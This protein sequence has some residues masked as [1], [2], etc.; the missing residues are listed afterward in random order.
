MET[1][2]HVRQAMK[3]YKR[4]EADKS[5]GVNNPDLHQNRATIHE[6]QEDYA[7]ALEGYMLASLLDPA[8][9]TPKAATEQLKAR[10][11]AICDLIA[12]N[13]R[14]K[15]KKIAGFVKQLKESK[16]KGTHVCVK[17]CEDG[18]IQFGKAMQIAVVSIF[19]GDKPPQTFLGV[20]AEGAWV[21]VTVYNMQAG[22]VKADDIISIPEPFF[23]N[24]KV[25]KLKV[26]GEKGCFE[27]PSVR[28]DNPVTLQANGKPLGESALL[29][30]Q[31]VINNTQ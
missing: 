12:A 18:K 1:V 17:E 27:F 29:R 2:D 31:L 8:W 14:Q 9:P 3:A 28:I 25:D 16:A 10:L 4:A 26:T 24:I 30:S 23:R 15:S 22:L 11:V 19:A 7:D 13:G 21:C 5:Q 20:D 6:Y